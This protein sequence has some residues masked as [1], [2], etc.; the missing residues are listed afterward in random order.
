MANHPS[1]ERRNRQ[2]I[3]R[4][5]RNKAVKT[6]TRSLVKTARTEI[7]AGKPEDLVKAVKTVSSAVDRAASKGV[8]H[9]RAASR[10]KSRIARRANKAAKKA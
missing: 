5:K 3:K 10:A 7:A 9:K 8:I 6:A 1:A 2:R 4:S